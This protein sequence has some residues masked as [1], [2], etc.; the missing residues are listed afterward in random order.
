MEAVAMPVVTGAT[1]EQLARLHELEDLIGQQRVSYEAQLKGIR[2]N[3]ELAKQAYETSL[4]Q[5]RQE[6]GDM[7]KRHF[8]EQESECT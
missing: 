7:K 6:M 8:L 4:V 3:S 1:E 2:H 5:A